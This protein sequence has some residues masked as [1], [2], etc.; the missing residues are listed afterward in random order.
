MDF[1]EGSAVWDNLDI[2]L[3]VKVLSNT[4]FSAHILSF[5]HVPRCSFIVYIIGPVFIFFI[6]VFHFFQGAKLTDPP[7]LY[8]GTYCAAISAFC[9]DVCRTL[10]NPANQS[11]FTRGFEVVFPA[12]SQPEQPPVRAGQA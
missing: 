6:P 10:W 3:V 2:D 9:E 8:W 5:R 7:V 12:V 11:R 1:P 4:F